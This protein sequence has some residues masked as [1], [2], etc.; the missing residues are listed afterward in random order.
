[1]STPPGTPP[2]QPEQPAQPPQSTPPPNQPPGQPQRPPVGGPPQGEHTGPPGG[3]PQQPSS[4]TGSFDANEAKAALQRAHKYDLGII[5]AGVLAFLFSMFPY[6]KGSVET[7]GNLGRLGGVEGFSESGTWSA[8][9]GF[10]GWFAA[11][12]ALGVAVMLA[13]RIVGVLKLDAAM[14]RLIALGGFAVATLFALLT[15]VVNPLPGEEGKE[16]FGGVSWEYSKGHA[17][18]FWLSLLVIL[19]GLALSVL[20][21]DAKD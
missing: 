5:A 16:S 11:L 19:A 6:Y 18:G 10:F 9:H 21:K 17:W 4:R 8:W 2:E 7:S 1:M 20:R 3:A 14:N 12:L 15:F 13:L